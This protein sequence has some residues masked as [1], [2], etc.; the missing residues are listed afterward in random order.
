[1]CL[2]ITGAVIG[3][4]VSLLAIII[5]SPNFDTLPAYMLAVFA[6]FCASTYSPLGSA[7]MTY[8][9]KQMGIIFALVFVGLSP[10]INI[11]QPLWRIWGTLLG[12]FAVAIVFF[13]LWP[14]YAGDSLLPRLQRVIGDTLELAP[15]GSASSVG[16]SRRVRPYNGKIFQRRRRLRRAPFDAAELATK[17]I[18][19][20]SWQQCKVRMVDLTLASEDY[21]KARDVARGTV[22]SA[23]AKMGAN[24]AAMAR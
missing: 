4:A 19:A 21:P 18:G 12:D 22:A 24:S 17:F 7:R 8:A 13:I 2:R 6:V 3:G 20:R 9:G 11:Y 5:V 10:S 14:E 1:M 15:S 23:D 16:F